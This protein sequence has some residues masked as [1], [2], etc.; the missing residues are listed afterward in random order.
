MARSPT[1]ESDVLA[2]ANAM[3]DGYTANPAELPN[4]DGLTLITLR[5]DYKSGR[6]LQICV[7][8]MAK[9]ATEEKDAKLEALAGLMVMMASTPH[10]ARRRMSASSSTVHTAAVMPWPWNCARSGSSRESLLVLNPSGSSSSAHRRGA[11]D[12]IRDFG[13]WRCN[14]APVARMKGKVRRMKGEGC[15]GEGCKG[16]GARIADCGLRI[17]DCGQAKCGRLCKVR[18]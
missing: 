7:M 18:D 2:L 10:W 6:L 1:R 8:A 9:M 15:K 11:G 13:S 4:A 14:L 16:E 17:A 3:V 12:I 5:E